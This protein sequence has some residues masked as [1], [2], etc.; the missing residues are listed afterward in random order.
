MKTITSQASLWIDGL[1]ST[2]K[3]TCDPYRLHPPP[4]TYSATCAPFKTPHGT[5][6]S[7][8][9]PTS[10]SSFAS[11]S[12][13]SMHLKELKKE[14][15][16]RKIW[17]NVS[18]FA[19][20]TPNLP[21]Q[22][23]FSSSFSS[24]FHPKT[25]YSLF[26]QHPIQLPFSQV[27]MRR[28]VFEKRLKY[29]PWNLCLWSFIIKFQFWMQNC[30]ILVD[31]YRPRRTWGAAAAPFVIILLSGLK[32][33]NGCALFHLRKSSKSCSLCIFSEISYW[34]FWIGIDWFRFWMISSLLVFDFYKLCCWSLNIVSVIRN[35]REVDE[36]LV[37]DSVTAAYVKWVLRI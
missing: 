27:R 18:T 7:D 28:G 4:S 24:S 8:K 3:L 29:P 21:F 15:E 30:V 35:S 31:L 12:K 16:R 22:N 5:I 6:R 11:H 23:L 1:T 20:S 9:S 36:N 33:F 32:P 14:K 10:L 13:Q 25:E 26:L 17:K 2:S 34:V 37:W 19:I